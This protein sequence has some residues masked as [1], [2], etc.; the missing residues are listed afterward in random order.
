M[1][2][3]KK[4]VFSNLEEIIS[5]IFIIIMTV[6]VLINVFTR[7]VLNSPITWSDEVATA[8]FVWAVFI[9]SAAAYKH[10]QHLGIDLLVKRLPDK[11]KKVVTLIVD[12]V[13]MVILSVI[14]YLSL[15][16]LKTSYSKVTP[17]LKIST[18]YISSSLA[19]SFILMAFRTIGFISRD[20]KAIKEGD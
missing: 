3:T 4:Q 9:G 14:V 20:I 12:L 15:V 19:I 17:V 6:L 8:C 1:K 13:M 16:Y 7:K 10:G 18:T 11:K 2:L 5:A